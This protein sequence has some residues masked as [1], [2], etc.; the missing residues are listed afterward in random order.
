[1]G[2]AIVQQDWWRSLPYEFDSVEISRGG[3]PDGFRFYSEIITIQA[4]FR[5]SQIIVCGEAND[6]SL[7]MT[8]AVAELL[9]RTA[10]LSTTS[11][12]AN[13]SSNGWAA[14][15]D[16]EQAKRAA[17]LELIERDA[18]LAQWYTST[19]FV[20]IPNESLPIQFKDWV[21]QELAKSEFPNLRVLYST[22]GIGPSVTCM[23]TDDRGYGV[24]GHATR[25]SLHESVESAIGEACRAA[26]LAISKSNW[27]DT[28]LLKD[29]SA[30]RVRPSAH[31]LFYAYHE[32]FPSWMF[33]EK[34]S[35]AEANLNWTDRLGKVPF[36]EFQF[37]A[38]L[39]SP[40]VIGFATHPEVFELQWGPTNFDRVVKTAASK[41]L[42]RKRTEW[43]RKPHIVA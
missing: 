25:D 2:G 11:P 33:G 1:M 41:R 36:G 43:N 28:L 8:K 30:A 17:T 29:E 32:A 38:E 40:L 23:L 37:H 9:E 39:E 12:I 10:L 24:T 19:P 31:A 13:K 20:E 5:G 3:R 26:H 14:H 6:Q 7:A 15:I 16:I 4:T 27:N 22:E 42:A 35:W 18:V 34:L 21:G